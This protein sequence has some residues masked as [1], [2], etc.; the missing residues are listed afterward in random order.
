MPIFEYRCLDC[1]AGFESIAVPG[2]EGRPTCPECGSVALEKLFSTFST[3]HYSGGAG[4]LTCCGKEERCASP[5]CKSYGTC[6]RK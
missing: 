6:R 1:G 3:P 4:G 5:P 2:G